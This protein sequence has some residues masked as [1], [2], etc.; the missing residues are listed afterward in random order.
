MQ[1]NYHSEST[2]LWQFQLASRHFQAAVA[3]DSQIKNLWNQRVIEVAPEKTI[4]LVDRVR[5]FILAM[6]EAIPIIG[7]VIVLADRFFYNSATLPL[8]LSPEAK[9]A[10]A[11]TP[12][13]NS[14]QVAGSGSVT[15]H[16]ERPANLFFK[17]LLGENP[18]TQPGSKE[19]FGFTKTLSEIR[20]DIKWRTTWSGEIGSPRDEVVTVKGEGVW[21]MNEYKISLN[22]INEMRISQRIYVSPLIP[23]AFYTYLKNALNNDKL[24]LLPGQDHGALTVEQLM[25][26][27]DSKLYYLREFLKSAA[28]SPSYYGFGAEG[29]LTMD[30]IKKLTIYQLGAM[31]V[32]TEK[33]RTF[34][35]TGYKI[36]SREVGTKDDLLLINACGIRGFFKTHNIPGNEK[37]E[38]DAKIM[39]N[40]FQSALRS[41]GKDGHIV[42]PAVG[43][44][45]WGGD[46][47]IYWRAFLDA[48]VDAGEDSVEQIY[49]NPGHGPTKSGPFA[50]YKGEEL[51]ILLEE[52]SKKHPFLRSKVVNLFDKKTDLLL[53]A[54][55]LKKA[56]PEKTVAI[57]N[58][59]DPDVTLGNHV[60][61]YVNNMN[62]PPTTEEHFTALGTNGLSF[63]EITNVHGHSDR[64]IQM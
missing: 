29:M 28:K 60:G 43:M 53:F 1:I 52:Y 6:L 3:Q 8:Q 10:I 27:N 30:E 13:F 18:T 64:I 7:L 57:F 59:S 12:A 32:K 63:E 35:E 34:V 22:E 41:V 9:K 15:S 38:M 20:A 50:G 61:E 26:S 19:L 21:G 4:S 36:R 17:A 56:L 37:H 40:T 33:Y 11:D 46:P 39:K 58:A 44:G 51:A 47:N 54:D 48:I 55:N 5:H 24:V 25:D 14:Y 62:H 16:K 45:V 49:I 42:F 31:I 2:L 23:K